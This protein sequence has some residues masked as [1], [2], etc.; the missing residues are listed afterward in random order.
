MLLT[1]TVYFYISTLQCIRLHKKSICMSSGMIYLVLKALCFLI[2][3]M[4]CSVMCQQMFP[5]QKIE[6]HYFYNDALRK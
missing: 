1:F 2:R 4:R 3:V 6:V 5:S